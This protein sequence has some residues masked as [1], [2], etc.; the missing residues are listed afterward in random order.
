[1]KAMKIAGGIIAAILVTAAAL[2]VVG[3]PAG[4]LTSSIQQR[5]A[6]ETGYHL[7]I[8]GSTRVGLWPSLNVT[9]SGVTLEGPSDQDTGHRFAIGS[10]QAD[11]TLSSL[12]SGQP[13]I[14][15]LVIDHPAVRIPLL[16]GVGHCG[17]DIERQGMAAGARAA[18]KADATV[19]ADGRMRT[20]GL[21]AVFHVIT[22]MDE[23]DRAVGDGDAPDGR[24]G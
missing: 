22:R 10:L 16:R 18:V 2:L 19:G 1:M 6:R 24:G 8:S 4:F 14:T 7:A 21:D 9:M 12:W 13:E 23:R 11:L 5:V 15:E 20:D 17:G 3:L